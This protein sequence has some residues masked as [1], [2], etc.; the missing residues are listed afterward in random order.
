MQQLLEDLGSYETGIPF[1][2]PGEESIKVMLANIC[3]LHSATWKSPDLP[4]WMSSTCPY[5]SHT[6]CMPQQQ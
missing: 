4:P 5:Q 3:K 6:P 1:H 2:D